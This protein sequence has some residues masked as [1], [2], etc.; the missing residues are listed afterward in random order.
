[1]QAWS[2]ETD[3][4]LRTLVLP[5]SPKSAWKWMIPWSILSEGC[6]DQLGTVQYLSKSWLG[7]VHGTV[8]LRCGFS[9]H[10]INSWAPNKSTHVEMP[11]CS[12]A[13][14]QFQLALQV[15][16]STLNIF[17]S[18]KHLGTQLLGFRLTCWV[19]QRLW[20]C[21]AQVL[22]RWKR[23]V[24]SFFWVSALALFH[25]RCNSSH[26]ALKRHQA[27]VDH[28]IQQEL[29]KQWIWVI[30]YESYPSV[31]WVIYESYPYRVA[32]DAQLHF[33]EVRA[34]LD[35]DLKDLAVCSDEWGQTGFAD[36]IFIKKHL[37]YSQIVVEK[38]WLW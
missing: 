34:C 18:S 2:I 3:W 12:P 8:A 27:G 15:L 37:R 19:Y 38:T 30:S 23:T 29:E 21:L 16:L 1:M 13:N 9:N 24:T 17:Q 20:H 14:K 35:C 33:G 4:W 31:I 36:R 5:C 28:S 26:G 11:T 7:V 25:S 22:C 6:N 32:V 10:L